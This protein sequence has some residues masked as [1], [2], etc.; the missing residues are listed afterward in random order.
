MAKLTLSDKYA[1]AATLALIIMLVV[2]NPVVM[3]A[4]SAIGIV[5]GVWVF[6][7]GEVRRSGYLALVG[8]VVAAVVAVFSLVRTG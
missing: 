7:Q 5:A 2:N 4:L 1:L 3:L 8:L 6:R